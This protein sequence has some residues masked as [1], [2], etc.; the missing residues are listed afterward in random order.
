[1]YG[2]SLLIMIFNRTEVYTMT[3][4][5]LKFRMATFIT[6]V[7]DKYDSTAFCQSRIFGCKYEY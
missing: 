6:L 3:I 5:E 7:T 1:M 2:T 4:K